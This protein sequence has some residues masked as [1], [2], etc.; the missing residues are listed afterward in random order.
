MRIGSKESITNLLLSFYL[1]WMVTVTANSQTLSI[2]LK[3]D[4]NIVFEY[5]AYV[6]PSLKIGRFSSMLTFLGVV[7]SLLPLSRKMFLPYL[8]E[9]QQC[10]SLMTER[11]FPPLHL[12]AVPSIM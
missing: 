4:I 12:S 2:T 1:I 11:A 3:F 9:A 5:I 8:L 6:G 7:I 10:R